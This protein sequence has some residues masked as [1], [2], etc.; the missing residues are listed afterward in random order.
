VNLELV[1]KNRPLVSPGEG[2]FT[3]EPGMAICRQFYDMSFSGHLVPWLVKL[4]LKE[5]L[6]H[7]LGSPRYFKGE[8]VVNFIYLVY[9]FF[10]YI[11]LYRAMS[12]CNV[13]GL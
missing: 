5:A 6:Q 2:Y 11:T 7:A 8:I 4:K 13:C 9:L 1:A 3:I 10:S 12:V